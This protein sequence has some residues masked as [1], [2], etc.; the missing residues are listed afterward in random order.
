[1]IQEH[2][3]SFNYTVPFV[4]IR[5]LKNCFFKAHSADKTDCDGFDVH[6]EHC[7]PSTRRGGT[8][9]AALTQRLACAVLSV[10]QQ[11]CW[12]KCAQRTLW[13]LQMYSKGVFRLYVLEQCVHLHVVKL[14]NYKLLCFSPVCC[15]KYS[16]STQ[17]RTPSAFTP[18][19]SAHVMPSTA[20][21]GAL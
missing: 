18:P 7:P 2:K 8:A 10:G 3:N 17:T 21:F 20:I 5:G 1:M 11:K 13:R 19:P 16:G 14:D 9:S 4:D 6:Y 15:F 12:L